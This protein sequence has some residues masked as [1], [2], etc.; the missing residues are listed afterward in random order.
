MKNAVLVR[1]HCQ[2]GGITIATSPSTQSTQ[3][4]WRK[5]PKEQIQDEIR[6]SAVGVFLDPSK[7]DS[8][9]QWMTSHLV[10]HD[11]PDYPIIQ[12]HE[13]NHVIVRN[14]W[15]HPFLEANHVLTHSQNHVCLSESRLPQTV[16]SFFSIKITIWEVNS[17]FQTPNYHKYH[18]DCLYPTRSHQIFMFF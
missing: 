2:L 18:V 16:S 9:M 6:C 4:P 3:S 17:H 1:I 8:L 5:P 11:Y 12:T 7:S 10:A 13:T 14:V 15:N